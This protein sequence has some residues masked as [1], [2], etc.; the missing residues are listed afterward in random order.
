M[1][2]T[3]TRCQCLSTFLVAFS[4]ATGSLSGVD[5]FATPSSQ[6]CVH[7][8]LE[9]SHDQSASR[10][11][12]MSGRSPVFLAATTGHNDD[13]ADDEIQRNKE[14]A[15]TMAEFSRPLFTAATSAFLATS[16]LF[17]N[18]LLPPPDAQAVAPPAVSQTATSI[19]IDLRSLPALTRK[20][21]VNRE[22]L[23]NYLIDSFKSFKPI[24]DLLSDSDTVTVSPPTDVKAAINQALTK[25]DAQ[26]IVNGEAVDVRVESVKGV[27][28]VRVI[29]PNIPRLPFLKDGTAALQF[30]DEIVDVAPE[31]LIKA[32]DEVKAF[33]K[34]LTWGAPQKAPIQYAG[35]SVDNFL[36]SKFLWNGNTVSLGMLGDLTNSEVVLVGVG[37][38]VVGAYSASYGYYIS[39]QEEAERKAAETKAKMAAKKKAAT[40]QKKAAADLLAAATV[41]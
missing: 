7:P 27:I 31:E 20:A 10:S 8:P 12:S 33:E 3:P 38:G 4:V 6:L 22:K 17:S 29:S 14:E 9:I 19:D 15:N 13:E 11:S 25:G 37:T 21:I 40:D 39:L 1:T 32:A 35:S 28:I 23:T 5:A 2:I 41:E 24:L 30:V 16:L 34:F 18:P 26:F 36:T